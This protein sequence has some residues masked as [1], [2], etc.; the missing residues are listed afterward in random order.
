[1]MYQVIFCLFFFFFWKYFFGDKKEIKEPT[2]GNKPCVRSLYIKHKQILTLFN[3]NNNKKGSS[4]VRRCSVISYYNHYPLLFIPFIL[5]KK[6][7]NSNLNAVL[8]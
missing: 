3:N 1:M 4:D 8:Y 5:F 2:Y 7:I 6:K